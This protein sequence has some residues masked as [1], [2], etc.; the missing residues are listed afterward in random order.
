MNLLEIV[1]NFCRREGITVPTY[2]INQTD[3]QVIQIIALIEDTLE[4]LIR[5]YTWSSLVRESVFT[6]LAGEDQGLITTLAP[7]GF[8]FVLNDTI[9]NR[10]LRLPFFG[11]IN[12]SNWQVLKA[13]PNPG[14]F[15]KYRIVRGHLLTDPNMPAG[16]TCAFEYLSTYTVLDV[17]TTFKR[18]PTKDTDTFLLDDDLILAGLS[19]TWKSKKGLD[20]AEEFRRFEEMCARAAST[21][22]TKPKIVMDDPCNGDFQPGIFVPY[23]NWPV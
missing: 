23:G 7:Y 14:P 11:P 4:N 5:N 22:A 12:A 16:H 6:S 10:T 9:F 13:L 15:Y 19:W 21:D 18:Y 20:Y 8:K 3:N 2:A 1:Q 17:D